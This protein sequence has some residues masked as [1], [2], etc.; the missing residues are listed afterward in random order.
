MK[1]LDK[2]LRRASEDLFDAESGFSRGDRKAI[3]SEFAE[4][5]RIEPGLGAAIARYV[6]VGEGESVLLRIDAI[7]A[8]GGDAAETLRLCLSVPQ[9]APAGLSLTYE[10]I[11]KRLALRRRILIDLEMF[12][13]AGMRRLGLV[14]AK[15]AYWLYS[16]GTDRSP[17][18]LRALSQASDAARR[19]KPGYDVPPLLT[20]FHIRDMLAVEG[21]SI[22][23]LVDLLFGSP[24]SYDGL[25]PE[26][27]MEGVVSVLAADPAAV[28]DEMTRLPA[29]NRGVFVN[30]L[31]DNGLLDRVPAY[32]ER[33]FLAAGANAKATREP[34]LGALS[35]MDRDRV[36]TRAR[37]ALDSAVV[38][39]RLA[40][41]HA[42][43][44]VLGGDALARLDV[45]LATEKAKKVVQAIEA[46]RPKLAL[47]AEANAATQDDGAD[48][49]TA[50]DGSRVTPPAFR[51]TADAIPADTEAVLRRLTQWANDSSRAEWVHLAKGDRTRFQHRGPYE[52]PC[53]PGLV[54]QL[55][56]VMKGKAAHGDRP[57]LG[58]TI[59][60][61]LYFVPKTHAGFNKELK[62][63]LARPDFGIRALTRM[64]IAGGATWSSDVPNAMLGSTDY[65]PAY[66]IELAR[67][68]RAGADFR[69]VLA[70]FEQA[71]GPAAKGLPESLVRIR[72]FAAGNDGDPPNP[73]VWPVLAAHF[74]VLEQS[75]AKRSA[76]SRAEG[77]AIVRGLCD[78][79]P[80]PPAR[81]L[82]ALLDAAAEGGP[83]ARP[84]ARVL[85]QGAGDLTAIIVPLLKETAASRRVGAARWLGERKDA[86]A[87]PFLR[88][89]LKGEKTLAVKAAMLRALATCGDDISDQFAEATLATEARRERPK[90]KVDYSAFLDPA[91][92]P[93]L[94]WADGRAVD[95][96]I[97]EY[98]FARAHKLKQPGGDPLLEMALE[99][100]DR[101]DA[102]AMGRKILST[103]VQLDTRKATSDEA[104]A[105]AEAHADQTL[106]AYRRWDKTYTREQAFA[107]LRT[108]KLGEYLGSALDHR[109]LL[110]LARYTPPGEAVTIVQR[111]LKDHGKR[112]SQCRALLEMLA[113]DPL[114]QKL[115]L[116]L[117][118]AK[119][120]KQPGARKFAGTLADAIAEERGWTAA[121]LAD[122]TVPT[123]ALDESDAL[124]LPIGDKVFRLRLA[125][126]LTLA[127]ENPDGR[128]IAALP[129]PKDSNEAAAAKSGK[130]RL[131]AAR[132]EL[133]QT[134]EVQTARLHEA[135]CVARRW[136]AADFVATF[137]EHPILSRLLRRLVI[138]GHDAGGAIAGSARLLDDGT[139]SD[140]EDASVSP[141]SWAQVGLAHRVTLGEASADAWSTHFEDYD[142]TP[143]FSQFDRPLQ[144]LVDGTANEIT[145]R[146]GHVID[147]SAL[148]NAA[149][150][151]FYQ[152]GAIIEGSFAA[153]ERIFDDLGLA[154]SI[155]FSGGLLGDRTSQIASLHGLRFVRVRGGK[156][157]EWGAEG[158]ELDKV[159]PVLLQEAWA[160]YHDI[161]AAGTGFE[162]H[163][164]ELGPW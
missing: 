89:A 67:R 9:Y 27:C 39:E 38:E 7:L 78:L 44:E 150:K 14:H 50:I 112:S 93:S 4:A 148:R 88:A 90:L 46:L 127:L 94:R 24:R 153:F 83:V 82:G 47:T 133:K 87:V 107:Q 106:K 11:N 101:D 110:A 36:A 25:G 97:V 49:Y 114:P 23:P 6:I 154:A 43:A 160:D 135:M 61:S 72:W 156:P 28:C 84:R 62:A 74:D 104:N 159:P 59:A 16:Y 26:T 143:L 40:G 147:A 71:A 2:L 155:R 121:E 146:R 56:A 5:D 85:L 161:A 122:R 108:A 77:H 57:V 136:D 138:S 34:A 99:R 139:L 66:A 158:I 141:E 129:T 75:I 95:P 123:L 70:L 157:S 103:F 31:A 113:A 105:Y 21:A 140:A 35:K 119:R 51:E 42:L 163:W 91:A 131:S 48:G 124:P 117:T 118:A 3:L 102:A 65:G 60:P 134:I 64:V 164:E 45:H 132:K 13:A 53:D 15:A 63:L 37:L 120:H 149:A 128:S 144:P 32:F 111:Y 145:D 126:D 20:A 73:T 86:A 52:V 100:L 55:V 142:V 19:H 109:G 69:E 12:D 17:Q 125:D 18:W 130:A 10:D 68:I 115:Q 137:L 54:P 41:V 116:I 152:P 96:V 8:R 151:R 22:A 79:F 76:L 1:L 33:I 98:W 29:R 58:R 30:Y 80:K 81:F 92:L 162:P